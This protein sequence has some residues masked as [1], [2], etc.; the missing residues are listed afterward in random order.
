MAP[1]VL[2][3]K[4]ARVKVMKFGGSCLQKREALLRMTAIVQAEARPC[5]VVLSALK[6][7]G[8][9][10]VPP[11]A[12]MYL[13]TALP[14][15]AAGMKSLDFCERLIREQGVALTPGSG[16]GPE[17]EGYVRFS[18][19]QPPAVLREAVGRVGTFLK[20]LKTAGAEIGRAHV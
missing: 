10:T 18:L 9:D 16:F 6:E 1:V 12:A 14:R 7:I 13:W 11:K 8:W 4:L 15:E 17:G 20:T 5:I 19:I 3:S 2:G